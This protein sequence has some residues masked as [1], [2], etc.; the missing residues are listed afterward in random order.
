MPVT[1]QRVDQA[2]WAS[3]PQARTDLLRIYADAPTER[4]PQDPEAFVHEHLAASHFFCCAHF[5]DRLLGAVA[6]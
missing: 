3:D 2:A 1:L 4:L 6:V 5:N